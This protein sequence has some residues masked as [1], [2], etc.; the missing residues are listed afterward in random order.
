MNKRIQD[1]KSPVT[2]WR[3]RIF[4]WLG[5]P[6]AGMSAD[7]QFWLGFAAFCL[8][9]TLLVHNPFWRASGEQVYKEGDIARESI[10]APADVNFTD[11]EES[12][13][14]KLDA[15]KAVKPIFRYESNKSEQAV[16]RFLSSWEMLQRRG[17]E[18]NSAK[19]S[20]TESKGEIHWTGAGGADV[21][22]VLAA[23]IFSRNEL[24]AVQ[25]ALRQSSEGYIYDDSDKQ[26]F[27]NEVFVFDRSKPNLQSTVSMPESNWIP[28]S[29]AR[30]K[31][32]EKLAAVKSLSPKEVDAFNTG[33]GMLVEPSVSYDSV[34]TENARQLAAENIEPK[35]ISLKRG[36]KIANE[37]DIITGPM[38]SK[39]AALRNYGSSTRQV[40]RFIGIL[41][42]V[43]GLFWL[44]WK[45]VQN[46]GVV[47]RLAL[48]PRKTF[49]LLG[50]VIVAQTAL[51]ALFFG[52]QNLR[53]YKIS[54]PRSATR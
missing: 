11:T 36:Q 51:M 49:A 12:D 9:T 46:R 2:R 47:P 6:F 14:L 44:A 41:L 50:F 27:Q 53:R 25:S 38:L 4:G 3:E 19:Q 1:M 17:G 13:K 35:T 5:K 8:L 52:W 23:R 26:Y 39:I 31:L 30:S 40:N 16:Q 54:G 24:D 43:T 15:R 42:L 37:G 45:F 33:A 10:I 32:K 21:G 29:L 34:A 7:R 20:N 48:T 28:L 18:G 22:K